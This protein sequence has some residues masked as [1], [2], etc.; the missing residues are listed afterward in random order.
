MNIDFNQADF[1]F[2]NT[3][4][5]QFDPVAFS[6]LGLKVHW[7][8]IAYACALILAFFIAKFFI[9]RYPARF[10]IAESTIDSYFLW[11]EVG[12]ILGARIG[13][14][15]IYDTNTM[16][17]LRNPLEIF[18]PFDSYGNFVG[19]SGMS[20]HGGAVGFLLMSWLFC[21]FKK[22]GFLPL[23]DL[24]A[25]S[26]PLAYV[27]GRLGNFLNQE[28][29]GRIVPND[30]NFGQM[31][32]ILVN[33]EL[34]YPS[35][36]LESFLEGVVLFFVV[37]FFARFLRKSGALIA[38]YGIGYG[39]ARFIAEYWR[40]PDVQMGLYFSVDGVFSGFSMGQILCGIMIFAGFCILFYVYL[41]DSIKDR[42]Y[43]KINKK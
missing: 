15:L 17:Y 16:Y 34:R 41:W 33:G 36:L 23:M 37:A 25:I 30:D 22:Q 26:V 40:E 43:A 28:L 21:R 9:R 2:W 42:I 19:I 7:Y 8:G 18:S 20:F 29:Y 4:Y 35:Q 1:S 5:S 27:F 14:V 11:A 13:Y 10:D 24:L 3:I 32:G 12:V 38:I 39:V 31:I 6:I